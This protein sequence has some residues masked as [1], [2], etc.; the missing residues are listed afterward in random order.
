MTLDTAPERISEHEELNRECFC[1]SVDR[2]ALSKVLAEESGQLLL[3]PELASTHPHLFSGVTSFLPGSMLDGMLAIVSAVEKISALPA[4]QQAVLAYA[5]Q[6]AREDHGPHGV[7]MGYDF[8]LGPQGPRLIEIN[9]NAG[10]AFLNA[11]MARV[12]RRCC[13]A[14]NA[15][16][17]PP[18]GF[19]FA[20]KDMFQREWRSQRSSGELRR[21]AI[22]DDS[23]Q[24]QYLYPEFVI[25][26]QMLQKH[27]FEV[28]IVDGTG[29]RRDRGQ[30]L[31]ND[32]PVDLIYNRMTDFALEEHSH[33]PIR[34]AYEAGEVVLT[35]NP[36]NHAIYADK[37]NLV[38][39]SDPD[40]L[41][42]LGV[43]AELVAVLSASIP[44]TLRVTPANADALWATR[45]KLFFKPAGGFGSKAAFR[46]DKITR[47][48]WAEILQS[49]NFIAQ[50]YVPT[51]N[52]LVR[53]D[54][55]TVARKMD[56]RLYTY[57]G[58]LLLVASRLY[59]GQTTNMRTPGG[60]FA[61]VLLTGLPTG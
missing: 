46:G 20:V 1:I 39:L 40:M 8:H 54:G 58:E 31:A 53:V 52:R 25:A 44:T 30:L 29:F 22:T 21:I 51:S 26:R 34:R 6:L 37:R 14:Q 42:Q 45:S 61:P 55:E 27:D 23:P 2:E 9:T 18:N 57:C 15:R 19:D 28:E 4:Y 32:R 11:L 33:E 5:P 38:L 47:R 43:E 59:Q 7:F 36:R 60:G 50:T 13:G 10:G 17:S 56:V 12:Q 35:P 3:L 41:L 16:I 49:D 24:E 48:V